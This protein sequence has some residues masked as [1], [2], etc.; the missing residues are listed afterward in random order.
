MN[1]ADSHPDVVRSLAERLTGAVG[2][3]PAAGSPAEGD[4]GLAEMRERLEALGYL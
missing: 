3:G 4:D 2:E 1:L